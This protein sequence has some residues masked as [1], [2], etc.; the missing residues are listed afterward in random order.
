MCENRDAFYRCETLHND[1][2]QTHYVTRGKKPN[3]SNDK[4]AVNNL[5]QSAAGII[6]TI[7]KVTLP[8]VKPIVHNL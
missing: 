8:G 6:R 3:N 5:N 1:S 7:L 2:L 4:E